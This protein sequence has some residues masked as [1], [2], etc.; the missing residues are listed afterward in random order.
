VTRQVFF[1]ACV[2]GLAIAA[3]SP[4]AIPFAFGAKFAASVKVVWWL[5]PG[6]VALAAGKV[7][8]ADLTARGMPQYSSMF[9]FVALVITVVL[10][11]LLIP[12]FGIQGAAIASSVA[13]LADAA[14]VASALQWKLGV[15][16]KT[17]YVPTA[18]DLTS[19]R[20]AWNRALAALRPSA[21]S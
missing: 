2:S 16:W 10:D 17:L 9:A 12:R 21:V 19:Y 8:S 1:L 7:M 4:L 11:L 15:G 13:Y 5:L 18:I 14:L 20:Q 3:L 6:T